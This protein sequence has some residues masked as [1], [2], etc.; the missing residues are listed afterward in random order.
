MGFLGVCRIEIDVA[1]VLSALETQVRE[2]CLGRSTMEGPSVRHRQTVL[3]SFVFPQMFSA[4]ADP[5]EQIVYEAVAL[6]DRRRKPAYVSAVSDLTGLSVERTL[7]LLTE[8]T[9]RGWLDEYKLPS[10]NS[11]EVLFAYR[12]VPA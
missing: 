5:E 12:R 9:R 1:D 7:K 3:Y 4:T 11:D 10:A 2:G 8:L 6:F